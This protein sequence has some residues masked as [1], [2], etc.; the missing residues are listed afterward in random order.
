M[1]TQ[2]KN[3]TISKDFLIGLLMI[4]SVLVALYMAIS[5]FKPLTQADMLKAIEGMPV[6][7]QS[8][9][10]ERMNKRLQMA[11]DHNNI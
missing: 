9:K 6:L 11:Q 2:N 1:G 3:K 8:Y 5:S 4:V 7:K 10:I